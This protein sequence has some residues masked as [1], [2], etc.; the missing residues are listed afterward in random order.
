[1]HN[2]T[3]IEII[4]KCKPVYSAIMQIFLSVKYLICVGQSCVFFLSDIFFSIQ[5]KESQNNLDPSC[6]T[7]LEF[8]DC[9]GRGKNSV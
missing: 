2:K 3:N 5:K 6:E 8:W 4:K 7:D 9:F 1:M